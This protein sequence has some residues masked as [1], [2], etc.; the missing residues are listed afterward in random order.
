MVKKMSGLEKKY[1]MDNNGNS[2][3]Y[4]ICISYD[5]E[6]DKSFIDL[7][8]GNASNSNLST[9]IV[10][11]NNL[12]STIASIENYDLLFDY[13]FDRAADTSPE[14]ESLYSMCA[15]R[16]IPVFESYE[17]LYWAT[18]KA[19]M[20]L[21]FIS[22]GINTPHSIIIPSFREIETV[23][24]SIADLAKIGRPFIIKPAV[25]SGGGIG[26]VQGA[27]TLQDVLRARQEYIHDK[28][29]LQ[30][31]IRPM[32]RD[33]RSFWFRNFYVCG[34]VVCTW[35]DPETHWYET[36]GDDQ[37]EQYGLG[38]MFEI[39][40][41]IAEVCKLLFF[42]TEIALTEQGKF[43]VVDY[44]NIISD[45][46]MKSSHCDGVPDDIVIRISRKIIDHIKHLIDDRRS[47]DSSG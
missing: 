11:K 2:R 22:N 35:W 3:H 14:F 47:N 23:F 19:T 25:T 12:T 26:V 21:E 32:K 20:H 1:R 7:L 33:G 18:D 40:K 37:V 28:Y 31:M 9:F 29:L 13:M 45:M 10:D 38:P 6:Y 27:E 15:K 34:L 4:N 8:V 42:S 41:K 30:E 43:V 44:V 24:I 39:I 5:W 36:I 16:S 46:R 17:Q